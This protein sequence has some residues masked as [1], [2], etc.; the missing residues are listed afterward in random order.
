MGKYELTVL[1]DPK[2][3]PAKKKSV[4]GKIEKL[5]EMYKGKILKTED[6]G[7][8]KLAYQI[9]KK[10]SGVYL[11]YQLELSPEG[12]KNVPSKLNLDEDIV[13]HLIVRL[14]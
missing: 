11:H 5:L 2:A 14:E 3:T 10:D 4:T 8:K 9:E 7:E 13:R 12:A 6:W 1:I